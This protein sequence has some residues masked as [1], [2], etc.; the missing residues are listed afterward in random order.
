MKAT[1]MELIKDR[2]TIEEACEMAGIQLGK[3][4]G[5][6]RTARCPLHDDASPSFIIY[7]DS[8]RWR[9][10]SGCGHGDAID[11]LS[12]VYDIPISQ[13]LHR[14]AN[15]LGITTSEQQES[16]RQKQRIEKQRQERQKAQADK[17]F[18]SAVTKAVHF[19]KSLSD[20]LDK[21]IRACTTPWQVEKYADYIHLTAK[22][23][24]ILDDLVSGER[25][26]RENGLL[27]ARRVL[28]IV[29]EARGKQR[30]IDKTKTA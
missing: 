29:K 5:N 8:N 20:E 22:I 2:L 11:L 18:E 16:D 14:I 7:L 19:L 13:T 10:F 9:C 25:Q 6:T 28:F 21:P 17:E 15:D 30:D 4:R 23:E 27:A 26:I 24:R 1:L 3:G 12:R